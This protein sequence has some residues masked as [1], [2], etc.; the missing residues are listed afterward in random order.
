MSEQLYD[1]QIAP[2]LLRLST[3]CQEHGMAFH[4]TVEYAPGHRG[5]T[6]FTAVGESLEMKMLHLMAASAP[7]IDGFMIAL[8]RYCRESGIDTSASIYL[9][10]FGKD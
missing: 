8:S 7:N 3:L 1:E 4:A 9:S 5:S 6:S 2:E 10:R